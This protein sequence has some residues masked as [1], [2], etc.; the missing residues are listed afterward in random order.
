MKVKKMIRLMAA[1]AGVCAL[2]CCGGGGGGGSSSAEDIDFE[3]LPAGQSTCTMSMTGHLG[4]GATFSEVELSGAARAEHGTM[5]E[6]RMS[7]PD[8]AGYTVDGAGTVRLNTGATWQLLQANSI[9]KLLRI[10]LAGNERVVVDS[11]TGS[12]LELKQVE[13]MFQVVGESDKEYL[14][15]ANRMIVT[16]DVRTGVSTDDGMLPFTYEGRADMRFTYPKSL[17][18]SDSTV[19]GK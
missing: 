14:C 11:A 15:E 2:T 8:L 19:S 5:G 3:I 18:G 17:K 4:S 6:W 12:T 10:D 9:Q 7:L 1:V 13:I 16:Y